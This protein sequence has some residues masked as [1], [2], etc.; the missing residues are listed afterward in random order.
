MP[1]HEDLVRD[2]ILRAKVTA[3]ARPAWLVPRPRLAGRIAERALTS[4][5]GPPGAGK[6]MAAA[7]WA[8]GCDHGPVAWVTLDEFDNDPEVFWSY[9]LAAL[10]QAGVASPRAASVLVREEPG[11]RDFLIRIAAELAGH[12]PPVTLVLDEFHCVTDPAVMAGLAYLLRNARPGLRVVCASR[13]D[14]PLPLHRYRLTGDVT[15]IRARDLAFTVP[16]AAQLMTQHGVTLPALSLADLTERSEGWAAGLRMAAMSMADHPDPEQFVKSLVA[17]DSAIMAYLVEEVLNT[18]SP[19]VRD[20]LLRTS[21]L[22]QVNGDIAALLTDGGA[23][24]AALDAMARGNAFVQ[25]V[26]QGWY[27]YHNWFRAVLHLKLRCENP[28][29]VAD[30]HRRAAEWYQRNGMPNDAAW[31]ATRRVDRERAAAR[32]AGRRAGPPTPSTRAPVPAPRHPPDAEAPVIVD[33]LS[34][35]EREVLRHVSDMLDTADIAAEMHISINT[36]KTHLKS[37]FHKLGASNRRA[38]V[39]RARQL[40]LL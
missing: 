23:T 4:I 25:P 38:A 26:G 20:L 36:V 21:I 39:R 16:E 18:R 5:T 17:D 40:D 1:H 32:A 37:S 8:D 24:S 7:S 12:D 19:E 3:P 34:G 11:R 33:P 29:I 10:R 13:A 22:A 30:L 35:R 28:Q 2:P 6:T 9:V 27:R 31:H 15:E 14:P